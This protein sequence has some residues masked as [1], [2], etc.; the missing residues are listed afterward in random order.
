MSLRQSF[1]V[2]PDIGSDFHYVEVTRMGDGDGAG[3]GEIAQSGSGQASFAFRNRHSPKR[4][5][6]P[7][8]TP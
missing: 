2:L 7:A 6:S 8:S 3:G 1:R 5:S 4:S